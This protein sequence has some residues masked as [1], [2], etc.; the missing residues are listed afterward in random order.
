V[1][2]ARSGEKV[3]VSGADEFGYPEPFNDSL[4]VINNYYPLDFFGDGTTY[5]RELVVADGATL[6]PVFAMDDLSAGTFFVER[7]STTKA[8][9][10]IYVDRA[11]AHSTAPFI[12]LA[13]RGTL[14]QAGD[15]W[16][17]C[18]D[19]FRPSWFHII[20][21]TFRHA[22]NQAQSGAVCVSGIGTVLEKVD[23]E[24]TRGTGIKILGELHHMLKVKANHNGQT[25]M[26]GSCYRCIIEESETSFNNFVGH[27]VFWEA[28]GGKWSSTS[29]TQ[30]VKHVAVGNEGPGLWLDGDNRNVTVAY[31]RFEGNL[32]AG[33]FIE[34]NSTNIRI[35]RV[36][37]FGTRRLGWTGA[38]ILVQATGTAVLRN[39]YLARNEG[40]GIWLR[41][42][43]RASDGFNTIDGNLF[44]ENALVPGQDRADL[45]IGA[46]TLEKLCSNL[47]ANNELGENGSFYY[48]VDELGESY[49]G[50]HLSQFQCLVDYSKR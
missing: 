8:R 21:I 40:A 19:G 32:A 14:F 34:L 44:E 12:E 48:E 17:N 47:I 26:N 43:A 11:A 24:W 20:G 22:A 6:R 33:V 37:V 1:I 31:S 5:E 36:S 29:H 38:G 13:H 35:E 49:Q 18:E 45:Q 4:W 10:L 27:D 28:G 30:F 50:E 41:R 23:V 25:G 42:D 39:N 46:D 15:A 9:I 3:V 16:S 2:R 7:F